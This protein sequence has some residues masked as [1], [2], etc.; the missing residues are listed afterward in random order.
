MNNIEL[1]NTI[2]RIL[3]AIPIEKHK[4]KYILLMNDLNTIV[5][6]YGFSNKTEEE[7]SNLYDKLGDFIYKNI[8]LADEHFLD[9]WR[10]Y[11]NN[12]EISISD[13]LLNDNI[14]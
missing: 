9:I 5:H 1:L 7:I 14:D 3:N 10:A 6:W 2:I 4:S 8:H 12:Y 11:Y 13:V